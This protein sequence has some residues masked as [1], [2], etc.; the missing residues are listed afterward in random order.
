MTVI[1]Q[2]E[3]PQAEV[4]YLHRLQ[5]YYCNTTLLLLWI[6]FRYQNQQRFK[7]VGGW[8]CSI[9]IRS[10]KKNINSSVTLCRL[11]VYWHAVLWSIGEGRCSGS[12][13][14]VCQTAG[15]LS[16]CHTGEIWGQTVSMIT[17]Q[18]HSNT[19][20]SP[21]P[22]PGAYSTK[23]CGEDLLVDIS[24]VLF[25]E[26]AFFK[27]IKKPMRFAMITPFVMIIFS[28]IFISPHSQDFRSVVSI[29]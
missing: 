26:M 8:S 4:V 12:T 6:D 16:Y 9:H 27:L 5:Q 10:D 23:E 18:V 1:L 15:S 29:Q 20:S 19:L 22:L 25:R 21:Y 2:R 11:M 14:C 24:E 28:W 17:W 3:E 7:R 13:G